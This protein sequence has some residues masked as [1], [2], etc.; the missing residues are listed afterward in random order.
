MV[1]VFKLLKNIKRRICA[2][3]KSD[4]KNYRKFRTSHN[5]LC[6][7]EP[8]TIEFDTEESRPA[9]VISPSTT[10]IIGKNNAGKSAFIM[11]L[12]NWLGCWAN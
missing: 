9:S 7:V 10:L 3:S 1:C 4:N 6:F 8:E 5:I 11:P 2:F 12:S